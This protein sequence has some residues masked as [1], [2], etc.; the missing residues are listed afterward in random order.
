[1]SNTPAPKND[2]KTKEYLSI[3]PSVV[4]RNIPDFT[5]ETNNIYESVVIMS[6]RAR[7]I[8]T[9]MKE[10]FNEKVENFVKD[11]IDNLEERQDNRE[12]I[13]ISRFY[14][15]MPKP[16]ILATEEFLEGKIYY[17]RPEKDDKQ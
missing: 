6:K 7:Q 2:S 3:N 9:K 15:R 4:T 16:T 14:E 8:A 12:Q 10:E 13:E 11:A 17:I 5:K 1:M